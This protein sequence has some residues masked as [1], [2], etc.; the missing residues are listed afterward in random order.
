MR[1]ARRSYRRYSLRA[2]LGLTT[3]L[4]LSLGYWTHLARQ[5]RSAVRTLTELGAN[6]VYDRRSGA[7]PAWLTEALGPDFDRSPEEV[8][9]SMAVALAHA[10]RGAVA[11]GE[12]TNP[13]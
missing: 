10:V 7:T 5:Q 1:P 8:G 12:T 4:G 9:E 11:Q 13:S 2:L 6:C 3:V